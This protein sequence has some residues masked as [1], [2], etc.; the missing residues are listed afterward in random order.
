VAR[1]GV[2][3]AVTAIIVV[4]VV[5]AAADAVAFLSV[6][7]AVCF[8]LSFAVGTGAAAAVAVVFAFILVRKCEYVVA[9]PACRP[10]DGTGAGHSRSSEPHEQ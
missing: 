1:C 10:A 2:V 8:L 5:V 7:F 6:L 3:G 9:S 4:V